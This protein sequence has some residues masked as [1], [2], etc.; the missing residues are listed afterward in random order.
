MFISFDMYE[1]MMNND[2]V[3]FITSQYHPKY[4]AEQFKKDLMESY[5]INTEED[6]VPLLI[7]FEINRI[8]NNF[9]Y[10]PIELTRSLNVLV[11]TMEVL[12]ALFHLDSS[13]CYDLIMCGLYDIIFCKCILFNDFDTLKEWADDAIMW[14]NEEHA[15]DGYT[16]TNETQDSVIQKMV[17]CI[18]YKYENVV[19][20][21]YSPRC[22]V[23]I[24]MNINDIDTY[25]SYITGEL[26][27][28]VAEIQ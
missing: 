2:D 17:D 19:E 28:Y 26:F 8:T 5:Y 14:Y 25:A 10:K 23:D 24:N 4:S 3:H 6:L 18:K 20:Y 1:S 21:L 16:K 7:D 13:E 15:E 12:Y 22:N 27:T 9:K 11:G